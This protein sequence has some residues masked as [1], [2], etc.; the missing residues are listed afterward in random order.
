MMAEQETRYSTLR[1][2]LALLR[3][4]R[5]VIAA[6]T[7]AFAGAAFVALGVAAE[8]LSRRGRSEVF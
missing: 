3:R 6:V 5:F 8:D 4:Q 2:Y 1:D 7:I